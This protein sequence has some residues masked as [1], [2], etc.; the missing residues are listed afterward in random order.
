MSAVNFGHI[1]IKAWASAIVA[2]GRLRRTLENVIGRE[3][4]LET[5]VS[6]IRT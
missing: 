1:W 2:S 4:G 5:S 6:L 3:N